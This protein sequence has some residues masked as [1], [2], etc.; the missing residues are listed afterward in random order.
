[1]IQA[2]MGQLVF[3]TGTSA[4]PLQQAVKLL[5]SADISGDLLLE[6]KNKQHTSFRKYPV[7]IPLINEERTLL[8]S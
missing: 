7:K 6:L 2:G 5:Q 4:Y 8:D 1:M 3:R